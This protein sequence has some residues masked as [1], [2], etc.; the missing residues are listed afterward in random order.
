MRA[1]QDRGVGQDYF[2]LWV[3]YPLGVDR[4]K[5]GAACA[6]LQVE[7]AGAGLEY[8]VDDKVLAV[9]PREADCRGRE[10]EPLPGLEQGQGGGRIDAE[11]DAAVVGPDSQTA[12]Q[13]VPE[14]LGQEG[15]IGILD[16][17]VLAKNEL[18]GSFKGGARAQALKDGCCAHARGQIDGGGKVARIAPD[19]ISRHQAD[20]VGL[21]NHVT[22]KAERPRIDEASAHYESAGGGVGER[23]FFVQGLG[24]GETAEPPDI[25]TSDLQGFGGFGNGTE[26]DVPERVKAQLGIE[27]PGC[28]VVAQGNAASVRPQGVVHTVH[29]A[30]EAVRVGHGGVIDG[31]I[32]AQ[33]E[34]R[35]RA[36]IAAAE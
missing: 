23:N 30:D 17:R 26:V 10:D 4:R 29:A 25:E 21:E 2:G 18:K 8:I 22:F 35:E 3:G 27:H 36:G 28:S 32:L 31:G 7:G 5:V 11:R 34:G 6:E 12:G 16:D 15:E 1:G 19:A 13:D 33:G 14:I 20:F 9:A 24:V